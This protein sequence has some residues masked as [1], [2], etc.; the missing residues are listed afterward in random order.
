MTDAIDRVL[1]LLG[2]AGL[3]GCRAFP[4][5]PLPAITA[6]L[7]VVAQRELVCTPC[8]VGDCIGADGAGEKTGVLAKYTLE[9]DVY[10]PY[11]SGGGCCA[12]TVQAVVECL[13]PGVTGYRTQELRAGAAAYDR[14]AD[15]F[16]AA[17]RLTLTCWLCW[18]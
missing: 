16:H 7:V 4:A 6:P 12:D 14:N 13:L 9:L 18:R 5:D 1:T 3:H 15:C 10:T 8:A 2:G 11:Q 17:V